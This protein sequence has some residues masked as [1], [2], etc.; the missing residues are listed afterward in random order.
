MNG[1]NHSLL[2]RKNPD[3]FR[4]AAAGIGESCLGG[5]ASGLF[6]AVEA[7]ATGCVVVI[8]AVWP[9]AL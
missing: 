3:Q 9:P 6:Y 8:D 4:H 5:V 1:F 2:L 7:A